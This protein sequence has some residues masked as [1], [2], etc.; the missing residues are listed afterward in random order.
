MTPSEA[1]VAAV[2]DMYR[3]SWRLLLL[4]AAFSAV[5][6]PVFVAAVW[7][8]VL[9]GVGFLLAGPL[10]ARAHALRRDAR[11]DR[12]PASRATG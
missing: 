5:L 6:V 1:L 10:A 9:L 8:P 7:A 12:G 4:N 2:G 3:Q 11:P